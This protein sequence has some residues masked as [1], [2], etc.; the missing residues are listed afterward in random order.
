MRRVFI[1]NG[2]VFVQ[3]LTRIEHDHGRH[4]FGDGCDRQRRRG[5]FFVQGRPI[6]LIHDQ[7]H[8][9]AQTDRIKGL[10]QAILARNRTGR[11]INTRRRRC[12]FYLRLWVSHHLGRRFVRDFHHIA[13]GLAVAR[14]FAAV[15]FA[16]V[17]GAFITAL[18]TVLATAA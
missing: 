13:C 16:V 6:V 2:D 18:V 1:G 15:A 14:L 3:I 8:A 5:I 4:Q 12:Y 7:S 9:R 17:T 10:V 11:T